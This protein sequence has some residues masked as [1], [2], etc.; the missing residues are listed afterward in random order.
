M[1]CSKSGTLNWGLEIE[2]LCR[3]AI[4]TGSLRRKSLIGQSRRFLAQKHVGKKL[5]S[6]FAGL[7][8]CGKNFGR[9][10]DSKGHP[11]GFNMDACWACDK[12]LVSHI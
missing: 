8:S 12:I 11:A 3:I 4:E 1:C 10:M 7:V 5:K 9:Y 2:V 6:M